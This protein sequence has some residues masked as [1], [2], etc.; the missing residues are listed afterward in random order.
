MARLPAEG[1]GATRAPD[2][3]AA[4]S[5]PARPADLTPGVAGHI[6]LRLDSPAMRSS[7]KRPNVI[8]AFADQWRQQACGYAGNP[9]VHTPN[10]DR[11]AEQSIN[12]VNAVAGCPVCSPYRASLMTGQFPLTH[13]VFVND[14]YLSNRAVSL[15]QAFA[16]GGYDTAY[17]GK[18]HLDGH[19][20]SSYIPPQRRQGFQY[21]KAL[22]CTHDYNHSAYYAGDCPRKL[23]WKGYDA[24]AQTRDAIDY[25][26]HQDRSRPFLLV[27]SWGPPHNPYQTAPAKYRAL[28]EPERIPL[29]PNVPESAAQR[30]R[31]DLAGYYAHCSALDACVGELLAALE[32]EGIAE[33]TIFLFTSDHGDMLGSHGLQRK[34]KPWAESVRVPFLLRWPAG[35]GRA[36]RQV[37]ALIDAPDIM[38]TLLGLSGLPIPETVEGLDFSNYLRGGADPSDG[39]VLYACY[40]PFGEWCACPDADETDWSSGRECR[41]LLTPRYTYVRT[42][43]GPWLLYDNQA[44]PCQMTNLIGRPEVAEL[45][46]QLDA[47]LDAK[48]RAAGD[49]FRPG[50]EYIRHWGYPVDETGTVPHT[51]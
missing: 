7:R 17:I 33:Q 39:S 19:G 47:R 25:I 18:W 51:K 38:P 16:R 48:L 49:E 13:G 37:E 24:I 50:M 4:N 14:V 34:Q 44:D 36:G 8:I 41:G 5:P 10:L 22:E 26:R 46:A 1:D 32:K 28:Y 43:R 9:A 30:A 3:G 29:R 15:A 23:Y 45:Q 40:H 11:L 31:R 20:R 27:L 21:F 35:L 2:P 12:F 42:L 6:A